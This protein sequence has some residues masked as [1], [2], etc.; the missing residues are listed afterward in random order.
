[1]VLIA[2]PLSGEKPYWCDHPDCGK[3]FARVSDLRSHERTH[4][5]DA[6][7]FP[8]LH[9]GCGKRFTRPYD[10]KK[11]QLS[12]HWGAGSANQ[13]GD[14][15]VRA[16]S[17]DG[18][19]GGGGGGDRAKRKLSEVRTPCDTVAVD[20]K[21]PSFA[22]RALP[23]VGGNIV[24]DVLR[25]DEA[26]LRQQQQPERRRQEA[27]AVA[28]CV[29]AS[30]SIAQESP[31]RDAAPSNTHLRKRVRCDAHKHCDPVYTGGGADDVVV[32]AQDAYKPNKSGRV[33]A[34]AAGAGDPGEAKAHVHGATCGHV[35]VLHENHVDFL[36]GD[37][38]LECYD[39]KKKTREGW[40]SSTNEGEG[41]ASCG[42]DD[43]AKAAPGSAAA[44][45]DGIYH[46]D[47]AGPDEPRGRCMGDSH[48][49][50]CGH[51][52]VHHAGHVDYVVNGRLIHPL[53]SSVSVSGDEGGDGG[54][55]DVAAAF[56]DHG[57]IRTL[58]DNLMTFLDVVA[59]L[60]A[61]GPNDDDVV[62]FCDICSSQ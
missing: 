5:S 18:G 38:Q 7:A 23:P 8:C 52:V 6:K 39:G 45:S 61:P 26:M 40:V 56:E 51:D 42:C 53:G 50:E 27:D 37:G 44:A 12:Q 32:S 55:G 54:E 11:H 4:R 43:S 28:R 31:S 21:P 34:A 58:D 19:G 47:G 59:M 14:G 30:P 41:D 48:G 46:W 2:N 17:T 60:D 9:P 29:T 22:P 62:R 36:M 24:D 20:S 57:S 49:P 13:L 33:A 15:V 1:I 25:S 10:L 16:G 35:A 3:R